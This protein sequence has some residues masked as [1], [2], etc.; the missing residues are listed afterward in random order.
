MQ[1]IKLVNGLQLSLNILTCVVK[2]G[3]LL[4]IITFVKN[5]QSTPTPPHPPQKKQ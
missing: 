1:F 4:I 5:K 3:N 2:V